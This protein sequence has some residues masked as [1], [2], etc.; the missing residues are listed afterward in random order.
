MPT[1]FGGAG[2]VARIA[3]RA[4][5][6]EVGPESIPHPRQPHFEQ[7]YGRLF[8]TCLR[9]CSQRPRL[10]DRWIE[11]DLHFGHCCMAFFPSRQFYPAARAQP[12]VEFHG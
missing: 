3:L 7:R 10:W 6:E 8:V 5:G 9:H 12:R 4:S 2:A 11:R 1:T